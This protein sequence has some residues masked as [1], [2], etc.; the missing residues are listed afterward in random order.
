MVREA[1]YTIIAMFF[2][3]S[4][5]HQGAFSQGCRIKQS[6]SWTLFSTPRSCQKL[7]VAKLWFVTSCSLETSPRFLPKTSPNHGQAAMRVI[8]SKGSPASSAAFRIS[9]MMPLGPRS[10]FSRFFLLVFVGG[11]TG[12]PTAQEKTEA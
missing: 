2:V 12:K 9:P 6:L 4:S 5:N 7:Q 3:I 1:S 11:T 8:F 10:S